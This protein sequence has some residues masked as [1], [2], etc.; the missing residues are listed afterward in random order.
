MGATVTTNKKVA[1][2]R[3]ADGE[4]IYFLFEE[5]FEMN[6][7]PHSPHWGARA[8]GTYEDCMLRVF[9]G[10]AS[11]EGGSLQTRAGQT[12][13]EAYLQAWKYQF[14]APVPMHDE[15]IV[16][17]LR[18]T[19]MYTSIGDQHA[20]EAIESLSKIG[21]HDLVDALQAGPVTV[22]LHA[23]IDIVIALY[24]VRTNIPLWKV[25]RYGP[26]HDQGTESLAP[27]KRTGQA[28]APSVYAFKVDKENVIV[29]IGGAAYQHM[30][31]V[32]SAVGQYM[33]E[34]VLPLE[35]RC[36]GVAKKMIGAFRDKLDNAPKL[37]RSAQIT[38]TPAAADHS[39]Y[40]E[41]AQTLAVKL[42]KAASKDAAPESYQVTFGEV[43]DV[44]E[45]RLLSTLQSSQVAWALATQDEAI[46]ASLPPAQ[47][48]LYF[49]Q[50]ALF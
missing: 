37:P 20:A 3:R 41:N 4:I 12:T 45:E 26:P 46:I 8:V 40:S 29:S 43:Q 21:R 28:V 38:I 16:L 22:R 5:T 6:V 35:L 34:V 49:A 17:E 9:Q 23:D 50:E 30:G 1:A 24:G 19:S 2:F 13:P 32:Y 10:A 27:A 39:Y 7:R 48:Q 25:L 14:K 33:R 47:P 18:G 42:G 15:D 31:W 36:D 11:C 44:E